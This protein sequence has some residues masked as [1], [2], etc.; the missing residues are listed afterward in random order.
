MSESESDALT[1]LANPQETLA[2][3]VGFEPTNAGIKIRCLNQ[4][5]ESP[6][7]RLQKADPLKGADYVCFW[8]GCQG[9][10]AVWPPLFSGSLKTQRVFGQARHAPAF[11]RFGQAAEHRFSFGRIVE[12]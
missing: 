1:S 6:T 10:F 12:S 7:S 2:G 9:C 5:G 3:D 11:Q 4:L 8:P